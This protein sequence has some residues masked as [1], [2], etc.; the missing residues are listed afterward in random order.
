VTGGVFWLEKFTSGKCDAFQ[1]VLT[2]F[3][4]KHIHFAVRGKAGRSMEH[5]MTR[6]T[7]ELSQKKREAYDMHRELG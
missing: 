5:W 2:W 4:G 3:Q 6:D 7:D 1:S